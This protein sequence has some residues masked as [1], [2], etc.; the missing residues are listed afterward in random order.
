MLNR[1]ILHGRLVADPEL[2][3]TQNGTAVAAFRIAVDRDY[4]SKEAGETADFVSCVAWRKSAE[5]IAKYFR[6]GSEILVEGRLQVRSY[7]DKD[8]N[9][10]SVT[11]VVVDSVDFVGP[12][13][14]QGS[15]QSGE[16]TFVEVDDDGELPF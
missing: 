9:R 7:N 6:K 2:R 13:R 10:R 15:T 14:S 11:E 4:K 5:F 3:N 1:V 16:N 8:G 12:K